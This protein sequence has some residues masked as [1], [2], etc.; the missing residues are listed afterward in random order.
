LHTACALTSCQSAHTEIH[1]QP[2]ARET[3]HAHMNPAVTE[4]IPYLSIISP[5]G[6]Q[7]LQKKTLD[8]ARAVFAASLAERILNLDLWAAFGCLLKRHMELVTIAFHLLRFKCLSL[9]K[10][11][12]HQSSKLPSLLSHVTRQLNLSSLPPKKHI[13]DHCCITGLLFKQTSLLVG[14]KR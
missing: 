2:A 3:E 13:A 10:P 6:H 7:S 5:M 12:S 4:L 14:K 11:L 1:R 9:F 8:V